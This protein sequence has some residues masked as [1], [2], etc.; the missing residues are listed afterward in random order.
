M[1]VGAVRAAKQGLAETV[2]TNLRKSTRTCLS[3]AT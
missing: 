3:L 2:L 1:L